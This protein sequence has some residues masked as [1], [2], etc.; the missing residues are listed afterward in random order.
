MSLP[1]RPAPE[2]TGQRARR[3]R[4]EA[5]FAAHGR[6][7]YAYARR[8]A[9]A[10]DADEVVSETFLVAWRRLDDV[11]DEP[12]PWLLG[13]ARRCLANVTRGEGRQSAVQLRLA[14]TASATTTS[15]PT[16][17]TDDATVASATRALAR[18]RPSER[19]AL[20]LIA[21][22]GLTPDEAAV[23]L[24]CTRAAIYLRL[25]RARRRL[26]AELAGPPSTEEL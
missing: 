11:P 7:V 1:T 22:D 6:S 2:S 18:L 21:W 23:A 19:E 20:T 16:S 26:S 5:L 15:D 8:R 14:A 17:M 13:V 24:G 12:R 3:A 25:H 4:L 9:S 10:A